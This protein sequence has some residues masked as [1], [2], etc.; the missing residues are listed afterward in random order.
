M[1]FFFVSLGCDKNLVDSEYMIGMLQ[2]AGYRMVSDETLADVIIVNSCCFI[3]DAKEESI[4]TI[5]ELGRYKTEGRL[6]ALIVAGCLSQRYQ[7]E[8]AQ[9]LPE[10]DAILGTN[11]YAHI[12]EAVETA[13]QGHFFTN[14]DNLCALPKPGM[15]RAL[16][17]G[18]QRYA[19]LK[20]ADGCNKRCTYCVI[21]SVRGDYRSVPIEEL[22]ASARELA[23]RGC[24]ELI[25]VAQE[26]TLY[27][28]DLYGEKSLHRLLDALNRIPGL[29]WIRIMYCYPE[30][31]YDDLLLAMKRNEKVCHYLDLPIQHANSGLLRK[32]GRKTTKEEL[33]KNISHIREVIPDIV[34][35]TTVICGFPGE[36]QSQHEELLSFIDEMEF[37]RLGAF[38]YS[39]EEGTLAAGMPG[40]IAPEQMELW[41]DEVMELQQEVS[42]DKNELL[43]GSELSV[44]IEGR[45][46]EETNLYV[47]RTYRDAPDVDG[48]V[49]IRTDDE[50]MTGDF[51]RVKIT[52]AYEYDLI[53]EMI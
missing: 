37:D 6:K 21:P 20:I 34:L 7:K 52:G 43:K 2:A 25:L 39:A 32:M 13:L 42:A 49:Y 26:T 31:I 27:G 46:V 23:D 29:E 4:N 19:Y 15:E 3:G 18:L 47:G 1:N 36:T 44:F 22:T 38:P 10:V 41:R 5:I 17:T 24:R 14:T 30:E 40:Q 50:L 9:E 11:A 48:A 35:R 16:S 33:V 45:A 51:V 53:G 12:V 8:M 28:I